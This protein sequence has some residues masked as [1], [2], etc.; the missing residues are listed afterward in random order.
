MLAFFGQLCD[1]CHDPAV[2]GDTNWPQKCVIILEIFIL[3]KNSTTEKKKK[4]NDLIFF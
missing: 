2:T 1:W 3:N 4:K